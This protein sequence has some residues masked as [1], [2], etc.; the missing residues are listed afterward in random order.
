LPPTT[1]P[2]RQAR[3]AAPAQ[4]PGVAR[5]TPTVFPVGRARTAL[6][7]ALAAVL[8]WAY[9]AIS[10][11]LWDARF[12]VPI[13]DGPDGRGAAATV[14]GVLENGWWLH[15]PDLGAPFG[16]NMHDFPVS[17]ESL[18]FAVIKALGWV[19]PG[20][21]QVMN[22]YYLAGFGVLAAVTILVLRHL[23]IP[24]AIALPLALAYTLLPY[25]LFHQEEHITRSTYVSA[26]LGCLLLL[27][28][29]SW[30]SWFLR[31]P[32]PGKGEW[33]RSARVGRIAF[34]VALAVGIAATETMTTIFTAT[35]LGASAIVA[36]V[37]WRDPRQLLVS[38]A[39][40]VVLGVTFV[41][42]NLPSLLYWQHEGKNPVAGHRLVTEGEL[43]GLKISRLV[44]P[45]PGHRWHVFT[46]LGNRGQ[47]GTFIH[48]EGGQALGV[49]GTIGFLIALVG[50]LGHGLRRRGRRWPGAPHERVALADHASLLIV[51]AVLCGTIAGFST[52]IAVAGF[53]QVRTW[54]RIVILIAFFSLVV[55]AL[56]LERFLRWSAE[57]SGRR[58]LSAAL[59]CLALTAF[60][61]W[62]AQPPRPRDYHAM[63]ASFDNDEAFVRAIDAR[64]P[65]RS[66]IFQWPAYPFPESYPPGRMQDYD[67]MRGYLHDHKHLRWSYGAVKG[68][69][70]GDWQ[71]AANARGPVAAIPGMLGLGFTG[72]WIDTFGYDP[73]ALA[74]IRKELDK[75]LRV[76]PV[77]S[78]DGRFLFYDLRPFAARVHRSPQALRVDAGTLFGI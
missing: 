58:A 17:G 52:L 60:A 8:A 55:L 48:S 23:R 49:L 72:Y 75:T 73:A 76:K 12:S 54:N 62:D 30:R 36:A 56:A 7:A 57:R 69:P 77:V 51:L 3:T 15:N 61:L 24:F 9:A 25:H 5:D 59:L 78:G 10:Y 31:D 45:E 53:G 29:L 64:M 38:G 6:E 4:R 44:L 47:A 14:K 16:Q 11:R 50:L 32:L 28:S 37:R 1:T 2:D 27:W 26:P 68:R 34:A 21:A 65:D 70:R 20:Y 22:T 35:L 43:Y 63:N 39:L 46:D 42:L 41:G 66:E 19:L 33:R 67:H 18:Q 74:P 40:I 13:E 71:Q